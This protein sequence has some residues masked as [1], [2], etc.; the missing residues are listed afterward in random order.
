MDI[1]QAIKT[2]IEYEIRVRETYV[3]ALDGHLDP[4]GKRVFKLLADEEDGHVRYLKGKLD[5]WLRE[6]VLSSDDLETALPSV[7]AIQSEVEKLSAVLEKEDRGREIA[8]LENARQVE[9]ETSD[10]YIRMTKEL[11]P[12]GQ[13]FFRRFLEIE[14]GH[15]ALVEAEIDSLKGMGFWFDVTEFNLEAE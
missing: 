12:K 1:E 6:G 9:I 5:A 2:A 13:N 7:E 4:A 10:F 15:L 8:M 3:E 11:P 14:S